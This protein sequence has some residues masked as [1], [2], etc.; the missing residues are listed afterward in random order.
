MDSLPSLRKP[1]VLPTC[2][3]LKF[4]GCFRLRQH[5][6]DENEGL[7]VARGF[8]GKVHCPSWIFAQADS[9]SLSFLTARTFTFSSKS[10]TF[11]Y[12]CVLHPKPV[13]PL[14]ARAALTEYHRLGGLH[15]TNLFSS[16][17]GGCK[18]KV[19][20]SAGLV[21]SEASLLG[22]QVAAFLLCPHVVLF[23]MRARG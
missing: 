12:N 15:E 9:P 19:K 4:P 14:F 17:S 3:S 11:N 20:V 1:A 18:S 16:S 13:S 21:S 8:V 7:L 22:L 23:S 5:L 6:P 2:L 10:L